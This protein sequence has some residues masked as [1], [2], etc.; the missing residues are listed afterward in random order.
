M[1]LKVNL[2]RIMSP[3]KPKFT[4]L[5]A[6]GNKG[7]FNEIA[8]ELSDLPVKCISLKDLPAVPEC[9]ETGNTF[10]EN[11][12]QKAR[13]YS[14]RFKL[15]TLAD[16]SGLEVDAL[17]GRPGVY[18]ARY[19]GEPCDDKANNEKLI[20]E[21]AGVSSEKRTARFKCA[22][23]L[24]DPDGKILADGEGVIEGIIIDA[25]RGENGFG[26]DPHFFVPELG[27]T[28]AEISREEKNKISHRGKATRKL[29]SQIANILSQI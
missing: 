3:D 5:I 10:M 12:V 17:G 9:E 24:V 21:L 2:N 14:Q 22:M 8:E 29:K 23:V 27:K 7:K 4:I 16:D 25:A 26:Y 6:T 13:Y 11:A 15:Y 19:A 20:K 28:T 1:R 18:S